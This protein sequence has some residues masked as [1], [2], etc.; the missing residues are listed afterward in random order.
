MRKVKFGIVGIGGWGET[1]AQ[2]YSTYPLSEL[3][4]VCDINK[5]RAEEV[6]KLHGVRK[7][8]TDYRELVSDD[9][10]E[11]VAVVTPDFAHTEIAMA[12]LESG[13]H[14]L[15]EKPMAKSVDECEKIISAVEKA[16]V[17]FMVDFHN[18]WNPPFVKAKRSL[19]KGDLGKIRLIYS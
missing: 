6:A 3:V 5:E 9:E 8:Y 7:S 2:I 10:V 17:K 15:L 19:D 1:H 4:A 18:R 14:L 11:A 16:G 12:A 13:K